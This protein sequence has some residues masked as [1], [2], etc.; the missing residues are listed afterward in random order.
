MAPNSSLFDIPFYR[1]EKSRC[2]P[3]ICGFHRMRYHKVTCRLF[4][5][6]VMV[7]HGWIGG[8]WPRKTPCTQDIYQLLVLPKPPHCRTATS[9][10]PGWS[11]MKSRV[12]STERPAK[13]RGQG[14]WTMGLSKIRGMGLIPSK[15][16]ADAQKKHKMVIWM[17]K[18]MRIWF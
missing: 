13:A 17:W 2:I 5:Y 8:T 9:C 11:S 15:K 10:H 16:G 4:Q 6:W 12:P 1:Q 3:M 18:M 14:P 7:I